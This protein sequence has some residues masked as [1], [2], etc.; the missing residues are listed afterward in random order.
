MEKL[1]PIVII[2]IGSTSVI[3]GTPSFDWSKK[4]AVCVEAYQQEEAIC[5]W[6]LLCCADLIQLMYLS[7]WYCLPHRRY[8]F[9][10]PREFLSRLR[11]SSAPL[12]SP[13]WIF[14]SL[15]DRRH[16]S[17]SPWSYLVEPIVPRGR[18]GYCLRIRLAYQWSYH[19]VWDEI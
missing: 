9:Y 13:L 18:S 17:L 5:Y 12:C 15:L 8:C 16:P 4:G 19:R 14:D 2:T 6:T 10:R 3:F 1:H 11:H 7:H